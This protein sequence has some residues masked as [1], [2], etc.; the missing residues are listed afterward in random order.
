MDS[1]NQQETPEPKT[2]Y[3]TAV[4][5]GGTASTISQVL[6]IGV[7]IGTIL[8]ALNYLQRFTA[9][10]VSAP[11]LAALAAESLVLAVLPY[12]VARAWD[13]ASRPR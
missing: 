12:V 9:S 4:K 13:E 10:E 5:T 1:L 11:Q 8:G 7:I 6:W 2:N 3:S